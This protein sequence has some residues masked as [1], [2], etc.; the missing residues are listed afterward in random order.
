M[1]K[2]ARGKL[3]QGQKQELSQVAVNFVIADMRSFMTSSGFIDFIQKVSIYFYF[4]RIMYWNVVYLILY[5]KL[6]PQ[7]LT[8]ANK[9]EYSFTTINVIIQYN[10]GHPYR[11]IPIAMHGTHYIICS[12]IVLCCMELK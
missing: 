7:V 4:I 1:Q 12:H 3:L 8:D 9:N 6:Y 2:F 11:H 10:I 5:F